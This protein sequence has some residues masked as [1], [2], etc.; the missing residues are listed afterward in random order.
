MSHL[1]S[2]HARD[3]IVL[4]IT[5][6]AE[7]DNTKIALCASLELATYRAEN[8][9]LK[10]KLT[11]CESTIDSLKQLVARIASK[12]VEILAEL[13]ELRKKCH[14]VSTTSGEINTLDTST[15]TVDDDTPD[16]D[17]YMPEWDLL[18]YSGAE[19]PMGSS[20]S[21]TSELDLL[22]EDDNEGEAENSE[23]NDEDEDSQHT[24]EISHQ[25]LEDT[26][27]DGSDN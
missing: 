25:F 24:S 2:A 8:S 5:K 17:G 21:T 27:E 14:S 23:E 12:Q 9:Q 10:E 1:S 6:S 11:E 16:W 13:V 19:S 26:W 15:S 20:A 7:S 3:S 18:Q 22:E 4:S